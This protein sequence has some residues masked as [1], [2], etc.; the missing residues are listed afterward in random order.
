M[1]VFVIAE[2]GVNHNGSLD[3]AKK[4]VDVAT[5]AGANAIKFQTFKAERLVT[6]FAPKADYQSRNAGSTESQ[7]EMLKKLELDDAAHEILLKHCQSAG[8]EFLSTPFDPISLQ[9][10]T[11][12]LQVSRIKLSS[13]ELTNALLLLAAAKSKKPLILSTGM[14]SL[15]EIEVALGVLAFG[16]VYPGDAP[17]SIG[18]KSAYDSPQGK[19]ALKEHLTLL[20]CT[21][22]YPA[23]FE[24]VHLRAMDTLQKIFGLPVGFSDHTQGIAVAIAAAARGATV[25]EK[26]F[27]LDQNLSGPDHKASLEPT[28]LKKMIQ[29]IREV[30]RALGQDKK[31][32][33]PSEIKNRSIARRSL[34]AS[35][36]IRRGEKFNTDNLT[37]KRPEAGISSIQ[38]WDWIGKEAARDYVKDEVIQA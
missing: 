13:G 5:A 29:S 3:L 32:P 35:C 22:E 16:Y 8:I 20:Q 10:L 11:Q 7:F 36:D 34:V 28:E 23:P 9:F 18:F 2:A 15:V 14:G 4:M 37:V 24:D 30:E 38:Y 1:S 25:I 27:T 21:A 17:S 6:Y 33:A 12:T 26:H 19:V 31:V